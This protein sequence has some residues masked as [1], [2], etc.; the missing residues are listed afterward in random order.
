MV[1]VSAFCKE[2]NYTPKSYIAV[3]PGAVYEYPTSRTDYIV[4]VKK[5]S[6]V[7]KAAFE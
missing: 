3:A 6:Y 1:I 4:E 7:K 5:Q 2:K